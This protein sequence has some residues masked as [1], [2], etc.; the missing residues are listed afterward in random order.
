MAESLG[1]ALIGLGHWGPNILRNLLNLE[2]CRLRRICDVSDRALAQIARNLPRSCH[3]SR[4]AEEVFSDPEID[5]VFIAT[6]AATHYQLTKRALECGKHVFVEKPLALAN[7]EAA[8]LCDAAERAGL[9]L[10]VG[11][12]FLF[13]NAVR[14]LKDLIDRGLCG[15]IHY[16]TC[17]RTHLGLV[18][19]DVNVL[20]DLAP[21]D[22]S[23][24][25]YLLGMVP[26]SVSAVAGFPLASERAD[27]AFLHLFYPSNLVCQIHV[28][29]VDSNKVR[30]ACVIGS[31]ARLL[32]DDL[33]DLEP[34]R[35]FEKG[36]GAHHQPAPE[37]GAFRWILRDGDII[38]PRVQLREP[39]TQMLESFLAVVLDDAVNISDGRTGLAVTK[40]L[41]AADSS[42]ATQGA[43]Q[44][45]AWAAQ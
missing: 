8:T 37:F 43:P 9:K 18:R 16:I 10:M 39:L 3:L 29:W 14:M 26:H 15:S 1:V 40:V 30:Q 23:M 42:I 13:N 21:H 33:D 22:V 36:I 11:H 20:W 6:P 44:D 31:G 24:I 25:N 35:V 7:A 41:S 34:V 5:A 4:D 28:S 27:V 12:T 17:T 2:R 19:P 45:I 32:F 38:S